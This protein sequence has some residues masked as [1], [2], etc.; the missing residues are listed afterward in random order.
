MISAGREKRIVYLLDRWP[1]NDDQAVIGGYA[2]AAYGPAR[3]SL[4]LDVVMSK[5]SLEGVKAWLNSEGFEF[6]RSSSKRLGSG[7]LFFRGTDGE[8]TVD[9]L[10]GAVVDREARVMISD[11][12]IL[13]KP[14]KARLILMSCSTRREI[15]IARSEAIWALKLQAGRDQDIGDL[16]SIGRHSVDPSEIVSLFRLLRSKTLSKKLEKVK[17]KLK[18]PKLYEDSVSRLGRGKPTDKQN[19]KD[20][21]DFVALAVS[22]IDNSLA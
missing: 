22:I 12:W 19:R 15:P 1:F 2:I 13:D 11:T 20:W 4:N 5:G 16:F 21:S 17:G 14:K 10:S 18:D 7:A 3:Y 6:G 9:I 8:A